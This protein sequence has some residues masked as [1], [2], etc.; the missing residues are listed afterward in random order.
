MDV[1]LVYKWKRCLFFIAC[2][3][4]LGLFC[5]NFYSAQAAASNHKALEII[6]GGTQQVHVGGHV[7][8]V[9][10]GD[11]HIAEVHPVTKGVLI[12]SA[13]NVGETKLSVWFQDGRS[14]TY[15]LVV[16]SSTV[17]IERV[18]AQT[19]PEEKDLHIRTYGGLAY[20][21]GKVSDTVTADNIIR[22]IRTALNQGDQKIEPVNML[23]I[24]NP[25]Q[26][27]VQL[28]FVEIS[29]SN[30]R[31]M[32][33]TAFYTNRNTS[34]AMLGDTPPVSLEQTSPSLVGPPNPSA[35]S[36]SA[37]GSTAVSPFVPIFASP[38]AGSW[39]IGLGTLINNLPI[40]ATLA[41]FES[42]GMA[43]TLSEPSLLT[44]NGRQANFLSGGEIPIPTPSGLGQIGVEW[45]AYGSQ[46]SF[47][48]TILE[49]NSI[50][51]QISAS[52]SNIDRSS[53]VTISGT[54]VP[55][56]QSRS[57][58]TAIRLKDG[59]SFAIA[60]LLQDQISSSVSK[61]PIL[62]DIPVLG[63][64]FRNVSNQRQ[65]MELII[66]VTVHLVHPVPENELT[67]IYP[68]DA[69]TNVN[70]AEFYLM[71]FIEKTKTPPNYDAKFPFL[72][73]TTRKTKSVSGAAGFGK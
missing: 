14:L 13:K 52:V 59:Q 19:F 1:C 60:G 8:R 48:P 72:D 6:V 34:V 40:S 43:K 64:F 61:F 54:A 46:I 39:A 35:S 58:S 23:S 31:D 30:L 49:E 17:V 15:D 42:K 2:L 18:L 55:G 56:L 66:I 26:V 67:N 68:E 5:K 41:L 12:V 28:K 69:F 27:Q 63:L 16:S 22:I 65:E 37:T 7:E 45:K 4:Y 32:G 3:G 24:R 50:H 38:I 47:T 10:L 53:G 44:S 33:F 73:K 21:T 11:P 29:R 9:V 51:L 70:G 25:D 20:I 57:S 62:G 71:G 36:A